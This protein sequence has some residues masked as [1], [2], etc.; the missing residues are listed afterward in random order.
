MAGVNHGETKEQ[1]H[2]SESFCVLVG[3]SIVRTQIMRDYVF[4]DVLK[5]PTQQLCFPPCP[6]VTAGDILHC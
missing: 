5:T 2:F 6:F 3:G 4:R 1:F